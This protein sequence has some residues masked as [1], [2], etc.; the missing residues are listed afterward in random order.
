MQPLYVKR[1][2]MMTEAE[3]KLIDECIES[4]YNMIKFHR[5]AI[6]EL[7]QKVAK[8]PDICTECFDF[9]IIKNYKET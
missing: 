3:K 4:H 8:T 7:K 2:S 6:L 5:K 9:K 1:K